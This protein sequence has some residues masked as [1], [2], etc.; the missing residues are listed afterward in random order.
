M[1][2]RDIPVL[3]PLPSW[4]R[5]LSPQ[6]YST[7]FVVMPQVVLPP[8]LIDLK[9]RFHPVPTAF[10]EVSLEYGEPFPTCPRELSP[11]Q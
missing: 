7:S 11:Q 10:G 3:A 6:Q 4:P 9:V 5:L 1:G 8:A 2:S